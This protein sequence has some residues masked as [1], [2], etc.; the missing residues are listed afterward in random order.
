MTQISRIAE[1]NESEKRVRFI[2]Y[3]IDF[4]FSVIIIWIVLAILIFIYA[5]TTGED[6]VLIATQME[7]Y[8]LKSSKI[9]QNSSFL[10][11]KQNGFAA[12]EFR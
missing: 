8:S 10:F 1:R 12:N 5:F 6:Y 4:I 3:I 2:N 9:I 11:D 7:N